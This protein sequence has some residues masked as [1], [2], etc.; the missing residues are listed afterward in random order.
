MKKSRIKQVRVIFLNPLLIG[1]WCLVK[2]HYSAMAAS[3]LQVNFNNYVISEGNYLAYNMNELVNDFGR[4]DSNIQARAWG[5]FANIPQTSIQVPWQPAGQY[6]TLGGINSF[7]VTSTLLQESDSFKNIS[8][9]ALAQ[10]PS[11]LVYQEKN[12][13]CADRHGASWRS[14]FNSDTNVNTV[15]FKYDILFPDTFDFKKSGKVGGI[16]AGTCNTGGDTPTAGD[17]GWSVRTV[18]AGPNQNNNNHPTLLA[19]LYYFGQPEKFGLSIPLCHDPKKININNFKQGDQTENPCPDSE[20]IIDITKN[21]W[22][23]IRME[24]TTNKHQSSQDGSLKYFI[25]DE[26]VGDIT[27]IP[28]WSA[29]S[30]PLV[31]E[32]LLMDTCFGGNDEEWKSNQNNFLLYDNFDVSLDGVFTAQDQTSINAK[33]YPN[34][35]S[36]TNQ[37]GLNIEVT[38]DTNANV[39]IEILTLQGQAFYTETRNGIQKNE[40][41]TLTLSNLPHLVPG[42]YIVKVTA[43]KSPNTKTFKLLVQ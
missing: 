18:W 40:T 29:G 16:C 34:P 5:I 38:S 19:Y 24:I 10:S 1:I 26:L 41:T 21:D 33:L 7:L 3:V 6:A 15:Y 42:L 35:L 20:K 30:T 37:S 32:K 14:H 28:Y 39:T 25:N 22:T 23:H 4:G 12:K 2:L 9:S 36:S 11:L 43:N 31:P 17:Q 8:T 13:L 27:H